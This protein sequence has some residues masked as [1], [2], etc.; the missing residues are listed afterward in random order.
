MRGHASVAVRAPCL[1]ASLRH[2]GWWTWSARGGGAARCDEDARRMAVPRRVDVGVAWCVALHTLH[3]TLLYVMLCVS[4]RV[5]L[6]CH[7]TLRVTER[8]MPLGL[9]V[10]RPERT[11]SFVDVLTHQ[12]RTCLGV[13]G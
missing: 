5:T 3:V 10:P 11:Q 6:A 13:P 2:H 9:I 4:L 8:W 7:V 12:H 1:W